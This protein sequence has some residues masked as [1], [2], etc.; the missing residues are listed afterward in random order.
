MTATHPANSAI[1]CYSADFEF[2][3]DV[4]GRPVVQSIH[5][6]HANDRSFE[7]SVSQVIPGLV[8]EPAMKEGHPVNQIAKWGTKASVMKVI[9]PA[10]GPIPPAQRR[11]PVC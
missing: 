3:V 9:V 8:Y 4:A 11:P 2:V 7:A 5:T 1:S 6:L 10:G